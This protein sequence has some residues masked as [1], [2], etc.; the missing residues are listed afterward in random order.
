MSLWRSRFGRRTTLHTSRFTRPRSLSYA[1]H[2]SRHSESASVLFLDRF[3]CSLTAYSYTFTPSPRLNQVDMRILSALWPS[4]LATRLFLIVTF[5][6]MLV[7]VV[8][9]SI[10]LAKG[11]LVSTFFDST[12]A[13]ERSTLPVYLGLFTIA[14]YVSLIMAW[15]SRSPVHN[16]VFQ[17]VLAAEAIFNR[18]LIQIFG[19]V[20][21]NGAFLV[22]SVILEG[23]VRTTFE[24]AED[25]DDVSVKVLAAI[26]P[27]CARRKSPREWV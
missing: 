1:I 27:W 8:I 18:N 13:T 14:Q 16:S 11:Q 17:L 9:M 5:V 19:L 12:R 7:N 6:E 23:E 21:F 2:R 15:S 25:V 24:A 10:L 20:L 26:I 4:T 22:Y 3:S